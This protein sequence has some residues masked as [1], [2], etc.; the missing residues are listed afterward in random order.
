MNPLVVKPERLTSKREAATSALNCRADLL[1]MGAYSQSLMRELLFVGWPE[2][3][4]SRG[5]LTVF[6]A[7]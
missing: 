7:H 4:L 1:V 3:V 5:D 6:V 2:S